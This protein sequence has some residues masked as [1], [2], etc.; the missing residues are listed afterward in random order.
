M[1]KSE[2][3]FCNCGERILKE[4]R[5][6]FVILSN[7]LKTENHL[8]VIPKRHTEVP[9]GLTPKEL[10][11]IFSLLFEIQPKIVAKY[12]GC[13]TRQNCRPFMKQG[14]LKVDHV[15][16]HLIPRSPEDIIYQVV[17]KYETDLFRDATATD[18]TEAQKLI[19]S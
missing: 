19:S 6:A 15:H 13:D 11:D 2:C 18:Y 16:F 1:T 9:W 4:N 3:P 12:G 7:P 10:E 5:T 14:R 17:E 8:L